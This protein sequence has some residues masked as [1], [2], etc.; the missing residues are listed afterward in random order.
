MWIAKKRPATA[1]TAAT[2]TMK[3]TNMMATMPMMTPHP[4]QTT[5]ALPIPPHL[6]LQAPK[7]VPCREEKTPKVMGQEEEREKDEERLVGTVYWDH[8]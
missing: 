1:R 6:Q 3:T 4:P 2:K 5:A 7:E 8:P